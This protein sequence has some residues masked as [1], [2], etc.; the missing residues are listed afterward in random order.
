MSNNNTTGFTSEAGTVNPSEH[1]C[2]S[3][4]FSRVRIA[5]LIKMCSRHDIAEILLKLTLETN[6]STNQNSEKEILR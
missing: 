1:L 3:P 4:V 5:M 6:Q 2:S